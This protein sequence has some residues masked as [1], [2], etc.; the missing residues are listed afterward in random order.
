MKDRYLIGEVEE[1]LGVPRSTI[2][3]YIKKG[4][5]KIDKDESNGYRYFSRS[6]MREIM[7][8][9]VGR[10]NPGLN[11]DES[12]QRTEAK[13]LGEFRRLFYHQE[14]RLFQRI[15]EDRRSIELLQIYYR[16][17]NRIERLENRYAV[18]ALEE[19]RLFPE[20]FIF[21]ANTDIIEAGFVTSVF[22]CEGKE[23]TFRRACSLV[24]SEDR[25]LLSEEDLRRADTILPPCSCLCTVIKTKK[26]IEDPSVIEPALSYAAEERIPLRGEAYLCNLFRIEENGEAVY[27]YDLYLPIDENAM[28]EKEE[29][30]ENE[31]RLS[32]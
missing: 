19:I 25:F 23:I 11:P 18:S 10:S 24:F 20:E 30:K 5:L 15:R 12:V 7:H 6:D 16:M 2:R 4:Y 13:S 3:Y 29:K 28:N 21:R 9:V 27:Y 22:H 32:L 1:I 26:D 14:D 8:L 31:K 17:L